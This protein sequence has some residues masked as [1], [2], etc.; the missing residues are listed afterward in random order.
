MENHGIAYLG[1]N[2]GNTIHH[3]WNSILSTVRATQQQLFK[4]VA[5]KTYSEAFGISKRVGRNLWELLTPVLPDPGNKEIHQGIDIAIYRWLLGNPLD[6]QH[7]MNTI[8]YITGFQFNEEYSLQEILNLTVTANRKEN[9][10]VVITIPSFN[11]IKNIVSPV[12]TDS[13]KFKILAVS[14]RMDGAKTDGGITELNVPYNDVL[15][16]E[17]NILL[18]LKPEEGSLIVVAMALEFNNSDHSEA[19]NFNNK[20]FTPA[21]IVWAGYN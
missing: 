20:H 14:C 3:K 4:N 5:K 7:P 11:P 18:P 8:P 16:P 17:Q 12:Q 21:G 6:A 2:G 15:V 19:Y 1:E 13:I 10:S 9:N